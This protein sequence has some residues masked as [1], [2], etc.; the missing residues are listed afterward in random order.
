L[1]LCATA[2]EPHARCGVG[3]H[4]QVA[5][6]KFRRFRGPRE[7]VRAA[8][9]T[10]PCVLLPA[11][12]C[13]RPARAAPAAPH[14]VCTVRP[15]AQAAVRIREAGGTGCCS[16]PAS[17]LDQGAGRPRACY[18]SPAKLLAYRFCT[19]HAPN[20]PPARPP[21]AFV[22]L[23]NPVPPVPAT[24]PG[25]AQRAHGAVGQGCGPGHRPQRAAACDVPPRV[26]RAARPAQ[27]AAPPRPCPAPSPQCSSGRCPPSLP[28]PRPPRPPAVW[29]R[30]SSD[31]PGWCGAVAVHAAQRRT[32]RSC[33]QWTTRSRWSSTAP[34]WCPPGSAPPPHTCA[35][36]SP[37]QKA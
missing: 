18:L 15:A 29:P 23:A 28:A 4:L 1:G 19:G 22:R 12:S 34:R 13:A 11:L 9:C 26:Q 7:A 33:T 17:R 37:L 21:F 30:G 3:C 10:R 5:G 8:T 27:G 14:S 20:G 31:R 16:L 25:G 36:C 24:P 35:V 32:L 2:V 6:P